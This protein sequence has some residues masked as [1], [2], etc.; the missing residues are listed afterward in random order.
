MIKEAK[1]AKEWDL[2]HLGRH[3]HSNTPGASM[4][5]F[6]WSHSLEHSNSSVQGEII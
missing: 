3:T 4:K 1:S 6:A 2:D 5:H